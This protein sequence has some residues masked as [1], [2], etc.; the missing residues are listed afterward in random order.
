MVARFSF[1]LLL[2]A[3]AASAWTTRSTPKMSLDQQQ[4]RRLVLQTVITTAVG[5]AL[6]FA[7]TA[8][9][10]LENGVK[11][12]I[13]KTGTGP[14]PVRG[15]LAAIR[16]SARFGDIEFDNIF[17]NPEPYYTRIGSGALIKGVEDTLPLMRLGDRWVLTVPVSD[18][19]ENYSCR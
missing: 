15:E 5:T 11:V 9:E 19:A 6:P 14:K 17:D 1:S 8:A 13:K 12:E 18:I 16:F 2:L 3:G 7:S 10:T 4:S